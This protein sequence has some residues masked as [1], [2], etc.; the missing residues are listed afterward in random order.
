M[1][2]DVEPKRN[3]LG[4]VQTRA[5]PSLTRGNTVRRIMIKKLF[6]SFRELENAISSARESLE[7]SENPSQKL[8]KRIETYEEIL[9]KQRELATAMCGYASLGNW[10]EVERHIKLINGLSS[11]IRDDAQEMA[12]NMRPSTNIEPETRELMIC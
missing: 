3:F 12:Y 4:S 7:D 6:Q 11:M 8:I 10:P 5:E 9:E 2:I 1:V